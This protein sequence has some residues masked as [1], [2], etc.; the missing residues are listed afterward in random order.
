MYNWRKNFVFL[1]LPYKCDI[2]LKTTFG[3]KTVL[4]WRGRRNI[5]KGL[6]CYYYNI[7]NF[8]ILLYKHD[9]FSLV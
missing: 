7:F 2:S 5:L 9:L 1:H 3:T 6:T 8:T 4:I